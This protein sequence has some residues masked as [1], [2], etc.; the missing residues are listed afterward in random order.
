MLLSALLDSNYVWIFHHKGKIRELCRETLVLLVK[1]CHQITSTNYC[2]H[3]A[4]LQCLIELLQLLCKL[5]QL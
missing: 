5:M 1:P 2:A 3:T 4:E